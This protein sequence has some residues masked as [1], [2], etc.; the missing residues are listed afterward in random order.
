MVAIKHIVYVVKTGVGAKLKD[1]FRLK[2][3]TIEV[4]AS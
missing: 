3:K 2:S 4:K 1:L